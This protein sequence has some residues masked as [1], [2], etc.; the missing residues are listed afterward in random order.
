[1]IRSSGGA[2]MG[3]DEKVVHGEGIEPPIRV[4][5]SNSVF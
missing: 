4:N 3:L 2:G 5:M 1:L